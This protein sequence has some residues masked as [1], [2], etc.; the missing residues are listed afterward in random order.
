MQRRSTGQTDR[1]RTGRRATFSGLATDIAR[2]TRRATPSS[3]VERHRQPPTKG[4]SI[5]G[6]TPGGPSERTA[7]A[8]RKYARTS[9]GKLRNSS[10][11]RRGTRPTLQPIGIP[12]VDCIYIIYYIIVFTAL[13]RIQN[14][15]YVCKR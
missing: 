6:R 10:I 13:S 3:L 12:F 2:R 5:Q 7:A 15:F 14:G 11:R 4:S 8:G 9:S 1:K